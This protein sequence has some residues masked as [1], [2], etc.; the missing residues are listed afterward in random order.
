MLSLPQ[1]ALHHGRNSIAAPSEASFTS[2]FGTLL[3]PAQFL[4]SA[5]GTTA[6]YDF[7]PKIESE[8]R[9]PIQRVLFVHGVCTPAL[10]M[11][12]LASELHAKYEG[13]HFVLYDLWGHGLSSTPI[14]PHTRGLFHAQIMQLLLH[15]QWPSV[16]LVGFSFGGST[17]V[18]FAAYHP[19]C[20]ESIAL[21]APVG[22]KRLDDLSAEEQRVLFGK[23]EDAAQDFVFEALGGPPVDLPTG[24][25]ETV[26]Q[27]GIVA[28]ALWAWEVKEHQGHVASM[29]SLYRDGGVRDQHEQFKMVSKR[30]VKTIVV[31]GELDDVCTTEVLKDVGFEDVVLVVGAGHE[32]VRSNAADVAGMIAA[33]WRSLK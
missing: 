19:E 23:D 31:L 22:L 29:V 9:S 28:P 15:L 1:P 25:R 12:P 24:W 32:V 7:P 33:F 16:H 13:A 11:L 26:K 30:G 20:V 4:P 21:V 5:W 18:T 6:F 27:G 2:E 3:P 8:R 17:V 10:G 14:A